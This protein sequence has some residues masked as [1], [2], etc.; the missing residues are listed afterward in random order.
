[1]IGRRMVTATAVIAAVAAGGVAG[2]MIG[3]PALSGASTTSTTA[4]KSAKAPNAKHLHRGFGPAFGA[5]NGVLAA[6][7]DALHL[8]TA[9]L[10]K[11]L[12]DGKTTIADVATQQHVALQDVIDAMDA[13]AKTDISN[14]VNN[15]FPKAP[16]LK[17]GPDGPDG[18]GFAG[19]GIGV[20]GF[21][22]RGAV[23]GGDS[24]A[25][26]AKDLGITTK[27]LMTDLGA[28]KSIADIA[29]TKHID[30]DTLIGKL[31]DAAKSKLDAA[32][33]AG[34]LDQARATKIE[35]GLKD[36]ITK[37]VN[38]TFP[39]GGR[40]FGGRFGPGLRGPAGGPGPAASTAPVA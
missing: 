28:G 30:V 8:S 5:G 34:H 1:M 40:H 29:K 16:S 6:G 17:G 13:V 2:A 14:M 19:P 38:G 9:D 32:V 10:L 39:M 33:K 31:V 23:L 18:P 3:I 26:A 20:P 27:E 24:F 15:P 12:S 25:G 4:P 37:L 21:G 36:S 7:A 11:K 22:R 35:A